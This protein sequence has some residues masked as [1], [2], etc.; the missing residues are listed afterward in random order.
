MTRQVREV[1][2]GLINKEDISETNFI[3]EFRKSP[4]DIPLLTSVCN[5]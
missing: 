4:L 1:S 3:G 2:F 5:R